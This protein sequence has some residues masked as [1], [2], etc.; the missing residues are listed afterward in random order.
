[1]KKT[2]LTGLAVVFLT[3]FLQVA[4]IPAAPC[5][6]PVQKAA[7]EKPPQF[8]AY[9]FFTNKRCQTCLTIERLAREAIHQHFKDQLTS[10]RLQWHGINVEQ[11]ENKH[12][13]EDFQLYS[14][15]VI[16]AEY[17]DGKPVR[18]VNL[19]KVWQLYRNK[20]KYFDYLASE[21]RAFMEKS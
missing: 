2:C 20:D 10:G 6:Q 17:K 21:T 19:E 16:I 18:W 4:W 14:K 13:I 12:F 8:V 5:D 9:Y 1:M 7:K 11:P 15:S 3:A